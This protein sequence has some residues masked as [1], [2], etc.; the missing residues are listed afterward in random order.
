[1]I[2]N[3]AKMASLRD[4]IAKQAEDKSQRLFAVI[5]LQTKQFKVVEGDIIHVENN[6]PLM[7]NDKIK[8]EKVGFLIVFK[9]LLL[10]VLAV[11]GPNFTLIGRPTLNR[12]LVSVN[13]TV[14]EKTVTSP[15][16]KY[17][18]VGGKQIEHL[19]CKLYSN[20]S[21]TSCFQGLA[22]N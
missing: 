14:I 17:L 11:G 15:D 5:H 13:A 4:M 21:T 12:D 8:L 18:H 1:M 6:I 20:S 9:Y 22:E 16:I 3:V 7:F 2:R 10:Q 19:Q